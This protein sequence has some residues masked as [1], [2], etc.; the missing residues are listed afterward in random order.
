MI[1]GIFET[2]DSTSSHLILAE[3]VILRVYGQDPY[4]INAKSEL[5]RRAERALVDMKDVKEIR[6]NGVNI[7]RTGMEILR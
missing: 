7:T 1:E 3:A 5:I 2:C 6:F 4:D